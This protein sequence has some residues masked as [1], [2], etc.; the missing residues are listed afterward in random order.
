MY[1]HYNCLLVN[2]YWVSSPAVLTCV[3]AADIPIT[4]G[5]A[6]EDGMRKEQENTTLGINL[7]TGK[8]C[9]INLDLSFDFEFCLDYKDH[10]DCNI[11]KNLVACSIF[12]SQ[13]RK[14]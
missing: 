5:F 6:E 4:N 3:A 13:T 2:V 14:C 7:A 8:A 1:C 9:I 10:V 12:Y 11:L